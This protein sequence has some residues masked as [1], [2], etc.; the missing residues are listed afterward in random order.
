MN[1]PTFVVAVVVFGA[2]FAILARGFWNKKHHKSSC[3]C[4]CGGCGCCASAACVK[5]TAK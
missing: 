2:F 5:G 4:I 3:S 1:F